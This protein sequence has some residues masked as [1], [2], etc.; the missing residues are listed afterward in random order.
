[1]DAARNECFRCEKAGK[2]ADAVAKDIELG[3]PQCK[4]CG[5]VF[6]FMSNS[7][8]AKC[9][10]TPMSPIKSTGPQ[11]GP[12]T[13]IS[14]SGVPAPLGPALKRQQEAKLQVQSSQAH[15]I[16]S[17]S[18]PEIVMLALSRNIEDRKLLV[19][20]SKILN[21]DLPAATQKFLKQKK[22]SENLNQNS[23]IQFR[24]KVVLEGR[25]SGKFTAA[26]P[27]DLI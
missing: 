1:M 25:D 9:K 26:I 18:E 7:H 11:T 21:S 4:G 14:R 17:E 13:I 10:A 5:K 6:P 3:K 19:R 22:A 23:T 24:M 12:L 20:E 27:G 16:S 2:A 15:Y 8:C